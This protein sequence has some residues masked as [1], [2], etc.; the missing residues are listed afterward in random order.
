MQTPEQ[1]AALTTGL[2]RVGLYTL[3]FVP[4]AGF[5]TCPKRHGER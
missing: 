2:R 1:A 4:K 3:L 5:D